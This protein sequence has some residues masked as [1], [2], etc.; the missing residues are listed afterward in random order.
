MK[1]LFEDCLCQVKVFGKAQG[2]LGQVIDEELL[3]EVSLF[4]QQ[5]AWSSY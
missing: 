2:T 5:P 1:L 4:I 3:G